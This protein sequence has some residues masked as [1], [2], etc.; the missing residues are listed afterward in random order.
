MVQSITWS[1]SHSQ[2]TSPQLALDAGET[3]HT[4]SPSP[5]L[6]A[7]ESDQ[8]TH[9]Q[10][11]ESARRTVLCS[12][13]RTGSGVFVVRCL[14]LPSLPPALLRCRDG[15]VRP[16]V[17]RSA[18]WSDNRA[19]AARS[20]NKPWRRSGNKG[21]H[22]EGEAAEERHSERDRATDSQHDRSV[23][24]PSR[25]PLCPC[26]RCVPSVLLVAPRQPSLD[27]RHNR[28][29]QWGS[30]HLSHVCGRGVDSGG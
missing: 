26:P 2:F 24:S 5:P 12:V 30:H 1:R 8:R 13:R 10:R 17:T 29:Q 15:G 11:G 3:Q 4:T 28:R 20:N 27:P 23:P 19:T 18:Q 9:G 7:R 22:R 21:R 25:S 16:P 14:L 6:R